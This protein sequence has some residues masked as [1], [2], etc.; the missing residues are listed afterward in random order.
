LGLHATLPLTGITYLQLL[1]AVAALVLGVIVA[2]IVLVLFRRSMKRTQLPDVLVEFL[3][4]FLGALLYVVVLLLVLA[5]LGVTIGSILVSLSAVVGLILGFGMSDTVNN[6]ASGTW[7]AALRP[8]D[9]GE[10]VTINGKTGKVNAVGI[11]ATELLT[12]DNVLI[13]IPNG[14]VWGSA[15]ENYTRM[16]KRRADVAVGIA[17]GASVDKAVEV[18][19]QAMKSH[20]LVVDDPEPAVVLTELADSSVNLSVRPWTATENYW[21]VKG[22][23]AKTVLKG[24]PEAGVEIPFPQL[25][26]HMVKEQ[27]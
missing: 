15:I 14:Q 7:I 8:I 23:I 16:P 3:S 19:M 6:I 11:L 1:T 9:L 4:R 10:V 22:D 2:R 25:D 26:V 21:A 5:S 18:A 20:A 12:P 24:L 17:Y 13:T 27:Q